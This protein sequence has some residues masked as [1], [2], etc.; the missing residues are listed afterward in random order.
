M[1]TSEFISSYKWDA[2]ATH[3]LYGVPASITLAQ[4]IIESNS[5]NS[6]LTKTANNFFGIK[7]GNDWKGATVNYNTQE[8]INNQYQTINDK[9]R[10]Y[11]SPYQSFKDHAMFLQKPRYLSALNTRN[12]ADFATELKQD[13]YATA[14]DYA[15]VLT[16]TINKYD[17]SRYDKYGDNKTLF[18]LLILLVLAIIAWAGVE[19]YNNF[20]N[21]NHHGTISNN[22]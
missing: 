8:F 18:A 19:I 3:I 4:G 1:T 6:G 20:I 12:Y 14:P 9:F 5:G 7:A 2:I 11:A 22:N 16:D 21:T 13:G 10:S 17:L 15:K